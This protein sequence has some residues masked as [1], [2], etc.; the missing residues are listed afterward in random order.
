MISG[1]LDQIEEMVQ[2]MM[3]KS[4]N[5]YGNGRQL[6]KCK[7]CGKEDIGS[8]IKGHI[9]ANHLEEINIPCDLY[10][11]CFR[12]RNAFRKHKAK[13]HSNQIQSRFV[14]EPVIA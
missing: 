11:K 9:E 14:S 5:K 1:D 12:S 4:G 8:H 6:T 13:L 3:E 2:S 7:V 10:E